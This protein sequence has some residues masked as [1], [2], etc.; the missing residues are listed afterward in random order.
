MISR[1]RRG[2][3]AALGRKCYSD[4]RADVLCADFFT[5]VSDA[6]RYSQFRLI[7]SD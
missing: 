6:L 3:D 7:R 5:T 4:L 2:N 1:E